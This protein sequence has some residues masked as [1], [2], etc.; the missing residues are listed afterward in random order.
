MVFKMVILFY[1]LS[2]ILIMGAIDDFIMIYICYV[3]FY[4]HADGSI[5]FWDASAGEYN[6]QPDFSDFENSWAAM[7]GSN[8]SHP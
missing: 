6:L 2:S 1:A 4:R 7:G 8:R 5:K 3:L